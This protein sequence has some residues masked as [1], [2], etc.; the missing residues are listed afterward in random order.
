MGFSELIDRGIASVAGLKKLFADGWGDPDVL[1]DL[2]E[3]TAQFDEPR[4]IRIRWKGGRRR[5][6]GLHLFEGAFETPDPSL[7]LPPASQ[8]AGFQL[9]LPEDA[10]DGELPPVCIH[11]AGSGDST[12]A[13][14]RLLAAPLAEEHGIGALI[15]M[16]PYYGERAPADQFGTQLSTVVDQL[17]MNVAVI[18]EARSLV[19][20]LR[21]DGYRHVGLTGYSMGGY[22]AALAAQRLPGPIATIPCA[23]SDSASAP[24]VRSPLR[25]VYD[26]AMLDSQLPGDDSAASLMSELLDE[27]AVHRQGRLSHP[28][29]AVVVGMIRDAF[30]PPSQVLAI[31]RH[32]CG[33]ELRWIDAGHTTGWALR[34]AE[35]RAAIAAAFDRLVAAE[36]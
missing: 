11:L 21:E 1:A 25:R 27:F 35:L 15:L 36:D 24:V 6:D 34:G 7:P 14:R 33:S 16:N 4:S 17:A 12:Y 13:G 30:I 32:W 5:L 19:R 8:L 31:H 23:A 22:S 10:F 9:L 2:I 3:R 18:E 28:E 20:W 29:C 26:W